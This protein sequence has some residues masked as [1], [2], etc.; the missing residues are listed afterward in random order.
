MHETSKC[1][2][3]TNMTIETRSVAKTKIMAEAIS[4]KEYKTEVMSMA[5]SLPSFHVAVD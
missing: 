2:A 3:D 4:L 1:F 5:G